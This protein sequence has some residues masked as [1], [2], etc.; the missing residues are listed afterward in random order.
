MVAGAPDR[1]GQMSRQHATMRVVVIASHPGSLVVFRGEMLKAMVARG[2]QVIAAAPDERGTV[3]DWL[4]DVGVRFIEVPMA[5]AGL[6]PIDDLRTLRSLH[7]LVREAR[8]DVVLAYTAKPV[9]YGLLGARLARVPLRV[10]LI[11]GRGSALAGGE[12]LKRRLLA[13]LMSTMYA[14]ALRGAHIVFFQNPDDEQF[15]RSSGLVGRDQRCV[16][17]NGSGVDLEHYAPAPLP[18]GPLTFL[19][20]GRLLREKGVFEFVDAAARV[21]AVRP[22]AH[23]QL[24]GGLDPN[25]TSISEEAL[26]RLQEDGTI[27]YLG[28]VTDVRPIIAGAHVIVLPSYHEGMPRSVLEGMSMGRAIITTDAPGCRET[29]E[30][31]RNGL[32][33]PVRDAD[34]LAAAMVE[35]ID[36]RATVA[37]MG[38]QSRQ[39]AEQRFDVHAVNR[40]LLEAM[41]L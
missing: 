6:D 10:A 1:S 40:V 20:V 38:A 37:A 9:I 26:A 21:K 8:A 30:Q 19:M 34:R 23:F 24:L 14:V 35:L 7:S 11:S 27:E 15:F 41:G 36:D 25:P 28:T 13:R 3:R 29:V 31:G 18:D 4:D 12:G 5:R 17:V 39:M 22:G 2:H 32:L 33:V 16:R